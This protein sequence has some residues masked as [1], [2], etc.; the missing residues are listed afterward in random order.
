MA[1][2]AAHVI[3]SAILEEIKQG[4]RSSEIFKI[5][6]KRFGTKNNL[7]YK[8]FKQ[9]EDDYFKANRRLKKKIED[10]DTI[11]AVESHKRDIMRSDERKE[12]LTKV[13]RGEIA[14]KKLIIVAGVIEY[15]DIS[16]D[17][18]ERIAALAEL[19]KMEGDYAPAKSV[20]TIAKLGI[21]AIEE[22]YE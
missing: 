20:V 21:D 19:N 18:K 17:H 15:H 4:K 10:I 5:I 6:N 12:Y 9:A 1:K 7:F 16:P 13:I 11:L 22:S 8:Y 14:I 2:A 3:I